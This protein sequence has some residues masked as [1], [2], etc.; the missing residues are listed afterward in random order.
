MKLRFYA[1]RGKPQK[2]T[3]KLIFTTQVKKSLFSPRIIQIFLI[4]S[5][6]TQRNL[7]CH[8]KIFCQ[9]VKCLHPN[10]G[11][12]WKRWISQRKRQAMKK[13]KSS[14]TKYCCWGR[15]FASCFSHYCLLP[16][17]VSLFG[18]GSLAKFKSLKWSILSLTFGM[19]SQPKLRSLARKTSHLIRSMGVRNAAKL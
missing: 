8:Q 1:S 10:Q 19:K 17:L 6:Q 11:F 16:L 12:L 14:I 7:W 2:M 4:I 3:K 13:L 15:L 9:I 18:F 5:R